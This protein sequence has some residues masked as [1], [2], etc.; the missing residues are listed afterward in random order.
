MGTFVHY[1]HMYDPSPTHITGDRSRAALDRQGYHGPHPIPA[2]PATMTGTH[3]PAIPLTRYPLPARPLGLDRRLPARNHQGSPA[4]LAVARWK[5]SVVLPKCAATPRGTPALI[6]EPTVLCG[7]YQHRPQSGPH[8]S[9]HQAWLSYASP[10][11]AYPSPWTSYGH[12]SVRPT[13]TWYQSGQPSPSHY[14]VARQQWDYT[15]S[16]PNWHSSSPRALALAWEHANGS[17]RGASCLPPVSN[18]PMARNPSASDSSAAEANHKDR[19]LRGRSRNKRWD[20]FWW[21]TALL[22]LLHERPRRRTPWVSLLSRRGKRRLLHL[23]PRLNE[24]DS[25]L[26]ETGGGYTFERQNHN[27]ADARPAD[28]ALPGTTS[29]ALRAPQ[30][31]CRRCKLDSQ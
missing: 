23:C 16:L 5:T 6:R 17:G 9:Y 30:G 20:H 14:W 27:W 15:S 2:G 22:G 7:A 11:T 3:L 8:D 13:P 10:G 19:S 25:K 29:A 12:Q 21:T 24:T 26:R 18:P 4:A 31:P 1:I 28:E